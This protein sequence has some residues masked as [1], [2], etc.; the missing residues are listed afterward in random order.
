MILNGYYSGTSANEEKNNI[1]F[2]FGVPKEIETKTQ[3]NYRVT[4]S[5][6]TYV[7]NISKTHE[8]V[9]GVWAMAGWW[10]RSGKSPVLRLYT[11]AISGGGEVKTVTTET[12]NGES[13]TTIKNIRVP[14]GVGLIDTVAT[15]ETDDY[16]ISGANGIPLFTDFEKMKKY[17]ET[18]EG[19]ED[20]TPTNGLNDNE[21]VDTIGGVNY[22]LNW[23]SV[24]MR[25]YASSSENGKDDGELY[26]EAVYVKK[27]NGYYVPV[28]IGASF[29][30]MQKRYGVFCED[31]TYRMYKSNGS[32]SFFPGNVYGSGEDVI[33]PSYVSTSTSS[34]AS[35]HPYYAFIGVNGGDKQSLM[36]AEYVPEM[37][38]VECTFTSDAP[39]FDDHD[40]FIDYLL[41]KIDDSDSVNND[42]QNNNNVETPNGEPEQT[43]IAGEGVNFTS[44]T[45][46]S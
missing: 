30:G 8:S 7:T 1:D 19:L 9:S 35:K 20:D 16:N 41:G 13:R 42:S 18:G 5:G 31:G 40:K 3:L 36:P 14:A 23:D 17:L 10:D 44:S 34:Y 27:V 43:M 22:H 46:V 21:Y 26:R 6:N 39:M 4:V 12:V 11:G 45:E 15:S 37:D 29:V 2:T 33:T 25:F 32:D 28:E 24:S 38:S